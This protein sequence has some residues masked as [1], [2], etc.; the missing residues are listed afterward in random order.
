MVGWEEL[1]IWK[2]GK[3]LVTTI[4]L[5]QPPPFQCFHAWEEACP[6]HFDAAPPHS[7]LTK[8]AALSPIMI[9]G[10]AVFPDITFQQQTDPY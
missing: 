7:D 5:N 9:A 2:Y 8:A 4:V 1:L 10:A 3:Y 6:Y